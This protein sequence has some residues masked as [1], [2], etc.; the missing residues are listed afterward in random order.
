MYDWVPYND[1]ITAIKWCLSKIKSFS[2]RDHIA[3]DFKIS[4]LSRLGKSF[5]SLNKVSISFEK[6]FEISLFDISNAFITLNKVVLLQS[7]G[8]PMG[9]PGSPAYSMVV[10]IFY[11]HKFRESI[12]DHSKF[13]FFRYFDDLRAIVAHRS[14]DITTK[15]LVLNILDQLRYRTYHPSMSL[16]LEEC[17][18]N[19]F[20]FLE[21][22]SV[23]SHNKFS[24]C[25]FSKNFSSLEECGAL[26]FITAQDYFSFCGDKKKLVRS[27]TL[28]GRL[29][30][31]LGYSFSDAD[32][33]KSFGFF[34]TEMFARS[35]TKKSLVSACFHM[36]NKTKEPIWNILIAFTN[37]VFAV[38]QK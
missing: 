29:S 9:A 1:I 32:L 12:H 37:R 11:E 24:S 2:R 15:S 10:C 36:L 8:C 18:D 30:A 7:L 5:D 16:E 35:Y 4:C 22:E 21:G 13:F 6:S 28:V 3:V 17:S 14:S 27:A 20:R 19:T 23:F 31:L 38:L 26:K 34:L 25:W 33:L